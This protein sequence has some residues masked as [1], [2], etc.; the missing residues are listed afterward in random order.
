MTIAGGVPLPVQFLARGQAPPTGPK[1]NSLGRW[2]L[3]F[4][5]L[6]PTPACVLLHCA[7]G[8]M[9]QFY[10]PNI[11]ELANDSFQI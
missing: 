7:E 10:F 3:S 8:Q 11:A 5:K 9:L 4:T 1:V 6:S 2:D